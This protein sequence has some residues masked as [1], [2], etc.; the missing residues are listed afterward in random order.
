LSRHLL[1]DIRYVAAKNAGGDAP[2]SA[3]GSDLDLFFD[4]FRFVGIIGRTLD[5]EVENFFKRQWMLV[6]RWVEQAMQMDNKI[7]YLSIIDCRLLFTA[8]GRER[9]GVVRKDADD[10]H[11]FDVFERPE[12]GIRNPTAE[13]QVQ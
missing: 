9:R 4:Y 5:L 7:P 2:S 1:G 12:L 13:H 8:P 11:I 3:I 6:R 10:I